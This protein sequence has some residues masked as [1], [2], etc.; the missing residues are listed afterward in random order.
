MNHQA[1]LAVL[2]SG[3]GSNFQAILNAIAADRL[4]A[5]VV[6]VAANRR[7]AFGLQ[8]AESAGIPTLYHS[9]KAYRDAGKSRAEYDADLAA[10]LL[11]YHPDWIV[12]AGW[13][14]VLSDSF[15]RHFP[16]RVVNLHPALPG[17]FPG[18]HAIQR[19]FEAFQR[20]EITETGIMVHLVPDER[21]DEGPVLATAHVP[22][23]A[24]DTLASLEARL[25]AE[26]HHL[27]VTTL[28]RLISP[29]T[30]P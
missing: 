11:D 2:L 28:T 23:F 25:H 18:T 10:C 22:I 17:Q 1:R 19:A 6:V 16:N 12:L 9:L 14:H 26:E 21:V 27:L 29:P 5:E 15:L 3:Y 13:M 24:D 7:D 30:T 4:P 20:G 8:R